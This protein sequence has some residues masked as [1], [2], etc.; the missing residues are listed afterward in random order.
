ML[1]GGG[2]NVGGVSWDDRRVSLTRYLAANESQ[3]WL[4]DLASGERKQVLPAPGKIGRA[5]V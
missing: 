5:H 1:P 2:W 4:L 3:V